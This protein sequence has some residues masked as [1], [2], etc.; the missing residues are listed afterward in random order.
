M[1]VNTSL[2]CAEV[3]Q[4]YNKTLEN[5]EESKNQGH[6]LQ[7]DTQVPWTSWRRAEEGI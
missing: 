5:Y 2:Q 1:I 3:G 7:P 4:L 6:L